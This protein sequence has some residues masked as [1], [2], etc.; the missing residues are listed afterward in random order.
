MKGSQLET[1]YRSSLFAYT[2]QIYRFWEILISFYADMTLHQNLSGFSTAYEIPD[3]LFLWFSMKGS[4][5][6]RNI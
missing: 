5:K 1:G 4:Y 2:N 6:E 3:Y